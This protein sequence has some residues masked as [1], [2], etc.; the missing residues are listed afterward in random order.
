[1]PLSVTQ[2][3]VPGA[4]A[5]GPSPPQPYVLTR[6]L[7]LEPANS[8]FLLLF[9]SDSFLASNFNHGEYDSGGARA[10]LCSGTFRIPN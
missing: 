2:A 6:A 10:E 9:K 4:Q 5:L 7:L 8:L 1:M 3:L